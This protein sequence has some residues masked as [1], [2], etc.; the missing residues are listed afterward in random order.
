MTCKK[1]GDFKTNFGYISANRRENLCP[2]CCFEKSHSSNVIKKSI[3]PYLKDTTKE[4]SE[5]HKKY[6]YIIEKLRSEGVVDATV[7]P[8]FALK[9]DPTKNSTLRSSRLTEGRNATATD[10]AGV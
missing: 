9:P 1:H 4:L 3:Q 8:I 6:T 2:I 5:S 10:V 7:V